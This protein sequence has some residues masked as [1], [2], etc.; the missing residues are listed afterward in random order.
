[1]KNTDKKSVFNLAWQFFK[2]TGYTFS[3]C[4]KKSVGKYQAQGKNEKPDS[5]ISL[6]EVRWLNTSSFWYVGKY[7][8]YHNQ[9]QT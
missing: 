8:P 5:R 1:M 3:E 6:Q 2:Q 7:T 4:L 9:P